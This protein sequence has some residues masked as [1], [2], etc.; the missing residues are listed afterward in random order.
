MLP[1]RTSAARSKAVRA[2]RAELLAM[3]RPHGRFLRDVQIARLVAIVGDAGLA[4]DAIAMWPRP[5]WVQ[6]ICGPYPD[7][8]ELANPEDVAD[9]AE[10]GHCGEGT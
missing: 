9:V 2:V 10:W 4:A 1:H 6:D 8:L 5:L 3:H 7:A